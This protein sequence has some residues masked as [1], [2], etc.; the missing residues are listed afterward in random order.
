MVCFSFSELD[1]ACQ[2]SL[3]KVV[4]YTY[5]VT[6]SLHLSVFDIWFSQS[7]RSM[8]TNNN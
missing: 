5:G 6:L 7:D 8:C 1:N 3:L 2:L 4:M